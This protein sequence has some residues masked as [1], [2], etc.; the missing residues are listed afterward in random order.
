M[1]TR[2]SGGRELKSSYT[3][4]LIYKIFRTCF[5]VALAAGSCLSERPDVKIQPELTVRIVS[6]PASWGRGNVRSPFAIYLL[7]PVAP[8]RNR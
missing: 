3:D 6:K 4:R 8:P 1:V 7:M 2:A 5:A